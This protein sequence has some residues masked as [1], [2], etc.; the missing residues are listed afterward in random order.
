MEVVQALVAF[1]ANI[2]AVNNDGKTPL[3]LVPPSSDQPGVAA[4]T[5]SNMATFLVSCGAKHG[6]NRTSSTPK[7]FFSKVAT[8]QGYQDILAQALTSME[9]KLKEKTKLALLPANGSAPQAKELAMLV[10]EIEKLKQ[11]GGR[12][13]CLDGGGIRGLI[14]MEVLSQLE[15]ETG[16]KVTELFDWIIGTSTGGIVALGLIYGKCLVCTQKPVNINTDHYIRICWK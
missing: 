5:D 10:S 9:A 14:Q 16:K 6:N 1:N 12:V 4:P 13:L 2:N 8:Q 15:R 3:D 7:H 11:G